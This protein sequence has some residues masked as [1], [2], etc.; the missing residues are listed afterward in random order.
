MILIRVDCNEAMSSNPLKELL[1]EFCTSFPSLCLP[2]AV[3]LKLRSQNTKNNH[4][5]KFDEIGSQAKPEKFN[6]NRTLETHSVTQESGK[7][8]PFV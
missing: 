4:N 2:F 5:Y 3:A 1:S 8:F 6:K 7:I